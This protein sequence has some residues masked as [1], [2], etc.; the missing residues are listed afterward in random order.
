MDNGWGGSSL[1]ENSVVEMD[2]D[3]AVAT[4][5]L[6]DLPDPYLAD[7]RR[8]LQVRSATGLQVYAFYFQQ[9]DFAFAAWRLY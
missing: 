4:A 5:F 3:A 7:F 9:A 8:R 2:I 1:K 6:L